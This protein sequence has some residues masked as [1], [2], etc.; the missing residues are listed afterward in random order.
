M[1]GLDVSIFRLINGWPESLAPIFV[2]FSE[3]TK[4]PYRSYIIPLL[5][6]ITLGMLWRSVRTRTTILLCLLAVAISNGITEAFKTAIPFER[7]C[8]SLPDVTLHVGKLT[9]FGTASS[10]AA[11]M[12]AVATVFCI[13]LGRWGGP[14]VAVALLTGLS[15]IYVGVHFPSQVLFGWASG[16]FCG[17]LVVMTWTA[18]INLRNPAPPPGVEG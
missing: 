8:V 2:F 17:G 18:L 14:W 9:T 6:L 5:G 10:H 7:P 13:L 3:A 1:G 16:V 15:R 4:R 12:A 11:N